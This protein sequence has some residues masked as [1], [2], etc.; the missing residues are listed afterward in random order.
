MQTTGTAGSVPLRQSRPAGAVA[1]S[2][3]GWSAGAAVARTTVLCLRPS[4]RVSWASS[5]ASA[6][7]QQQL[8]RREQRQRHQGAAEV[9]RQ[10]IPQT[11][12]AWVAVL[13]GAQRLLLVV[14]VLS[15]LQGRALLEEF[16][17]VLPLVLVL[18]LLLALLLALLM[19][20]E[21]P[22]DA[23]TGVQQCLLQRLAGVCMRC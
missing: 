17:D 18:L 20:R 14:V 11:S 9:A 5:G 6:A 22:R 21:Q 8:E 19:H 13:Q 16:L 7:V 12:S 1:G 15:A 3:R 2:V 10:Q 23:G 4:L